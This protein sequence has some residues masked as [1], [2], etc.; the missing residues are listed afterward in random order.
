MIIEDI[1]DCTG[2]LKFDEKSLVLRLNKYYLF[3]MYI[4]KKT[5]YDYGWGLFRYKIL[6]PVF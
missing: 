3:N 1:I 4:G 5:T 6:L 2:I